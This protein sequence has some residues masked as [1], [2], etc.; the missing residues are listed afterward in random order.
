MTEVTVRCDRLTEL[1]ESTVLLFLKWS[2][3]AQ[4][5]GFGESVE[6]GGGPGSL[7]LSLCLLSC[8]RAPGI[9]ASAVYALE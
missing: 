9:T 2:V 6:M 5:S 3:V 8:Y 7:K 4:R 1:G